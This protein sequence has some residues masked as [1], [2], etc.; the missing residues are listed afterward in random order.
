M[1][2]CEVAI[3]KVYTA[4]IGANIVPVKIIAASGRGYQGRNLKTGRDVY[5]KSA[6]KLRREVTEAVASPKVDR[7]LVDPT[8]ALAAV[9]GEIVRLSEALEKED[10]EETRESL[11]KMWHY[12]RLLPA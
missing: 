7:A 1:L 8:F 6:A 12:L 11:K 5:L 9:K 3:G 4:R 10:V 2:K